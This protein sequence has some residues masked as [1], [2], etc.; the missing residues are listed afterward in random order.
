MEKSTDHITEKDRYAEWAI[1]GI[2][3]LVG[4]YFMFDVLFLSDGDETVFIPLGKAILSAVLFAVSVWAAFRIGGVLAAFC[5]LPLL[6]TSSLSFIAPPIDRIEA[7][8]QATSTLSTE[9]TTEIGRLEL[10]ISSLES[11]LS[12]VSI[13]SPVTFSTNRPR[14]DDTYDIAGSSINH[15]CYIEGL[16]FRGGDDHDGEVQLIRPSRDGQ[17]W[18]VRIQSGNSDYV[19][20]SISCLGL[21]IE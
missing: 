17:I 16:R 10:A 11:R 8:E 19:N 6:V 5:T 4:L 7:L 18:R 15:V 9:L 1:L 3:S 21:P 13:I 14:T 20:A 12:K 2:L